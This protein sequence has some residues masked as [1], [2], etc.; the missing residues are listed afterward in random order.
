MWA[1]VDVRLGHGTIRRLKPSLKK[2]EIQA[3]SGSYMQPRPDM[4]AGISNHHLR[5]FFDGNGNVHNWTT[6]GHIS[7]G[8]DG[9]AQA[10]Q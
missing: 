7:V 3:Q 10:F 8:R 6:Y 4:R 5:L 1:K 2:T 9:V